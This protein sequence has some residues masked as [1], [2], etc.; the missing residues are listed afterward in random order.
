M[1]EEKKYQIYKH[2]ELVESI[3][4][5]N[6]KAQLKVYD[7][8]YKAMYNTSLYIV[9][10][11]FLAEDIMQESF[12]DAFNKIETFQWKSSFGA[13]LKRI[14][15]NKSLDALR[16][17]HEFVPI[18][19]ELTEMPDEI[20]VDDDIDIKVEEIKVAMKLISENN[21]VILALHL[22]DG[23]DHQEIAQILG[24][25]YNNVRVRYMRAKNNLIEKILLNKSQQVLN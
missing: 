13:W 7:L 4:D 1:Q 15:I 25:S 19:E 22:F 9:N 2:Q 6:P 16:K 14:V 21:R 18:S 11:S 17:K 12:L 24:L 5:G 3:A 10:D 20:I 23:Y 8:Y